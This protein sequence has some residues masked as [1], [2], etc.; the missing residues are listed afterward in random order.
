MDRTRKCRPSSPAEDTTEVGDCPNNALPLH[1]S[2]GAPE[3]REG[4][5]LR[6]FGVCRALQTERPIGGHDREL[7]SYGFIGGSTARWR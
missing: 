7:M 3:R 4:R 1:C 2:P 6:H 5:T